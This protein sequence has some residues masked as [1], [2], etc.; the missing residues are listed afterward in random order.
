[1]VRAP[2]RAQQGPALGIRGSKGVRAALPFP[3]LGLDSDN[4]AEFIN[5]EFLRYCTEEEGSSD[6]TATS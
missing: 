6:F 2:R 3:L 1:M 4:G 5:N